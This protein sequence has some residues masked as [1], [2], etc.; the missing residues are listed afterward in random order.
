MRLYRPVQE[1][2]ERFALH[3]TRHR[4]DA[5]EL[6]AQTLATAYEGMVGMRDE[7]AFLSYL[8]TI[9]RRTWYHQR[10]RQQREVATAPED[11]TVLF[12]DVDPSVRTEVRLIYEAMAQLPDEQ[13]EALILFEVMG[14][15]IHD[16]A[17][18]QESTVSAVKV[19]LHR[20][21]QSVRAMIR[22][23]PNV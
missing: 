16:I 19:R 23:V 3:L 10:R 14:F 20:A 12:D 13:R 5:R 4:Q 9:A 22:E 21:R 15:P 1:Q 18:M 17:R 2:V 7:A 11:L 6:V 8:F